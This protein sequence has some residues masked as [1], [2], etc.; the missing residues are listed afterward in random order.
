MWYKFIKTSQ[1]W[2]IDEA[3][4][5][6]EIMYKLHEMYYKYTTIAQSGFSGH[7]KRRENILAKIEESFYDLLGD[8]LEPLQNTF[9]IWLENHALTNASDWG[10]SRVFDMYGEHEYNPE[11]HTHNTITSIL[12]EYAKY[13]NPDEYKSKAF[14]PY[15]RANYLDSKFKDIVRIVDLH[16]GEMP[17][18]R[19]L[20]ESFSETWHM[21]EVDM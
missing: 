12:N 16:L 5:F 13:S 14:N 20:L 8:V 17:E 19:D 7:E 2:A 15:S 18:T 21:N 11:D 9:R 3:T 10:R 4:D 6:S 1:V